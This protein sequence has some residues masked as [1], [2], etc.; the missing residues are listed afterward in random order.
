MKAREKDKRFFNRKPQLDASARASSSIENPRSRIP[1]PH[2]CV[3]E[4][5]DIHPQDMSDYMDTIGRDLF[6]G[7]LEQVLSQFKEADNFGSLIRPAVT[8][9]SEVL[10]ILRK[11]KMDQELLLVS[12]HQQVLKALRQADYLSPKY[13][14]VVANPPYMGGRGMNLALTT[15]ANNNFN[16]AKTD[17]FAMFIDRCVELTADHGLTSM[18]TM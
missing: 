12:S 4:N 11:R 7:G 18:I 8:D 13:H 17:L 3:L 2:I 16:D 5:I 6:T 10:E 15:F 14:V 9:V 1:N